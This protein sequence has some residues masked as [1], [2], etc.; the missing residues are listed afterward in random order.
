MKLDFTPGEKYQYSNLGLSLLGYVLCRKSGKSNA[1]KLA[2]N[3]SQLGRELLAN[4]EA[5]P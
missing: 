1:H 3:I 4:L 5:Q 2:E